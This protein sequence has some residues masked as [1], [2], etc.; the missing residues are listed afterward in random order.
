MEE[1]RRQVQQMI[2]DLKDKTV[3][4]NMNDLEYGEYTALAKVIDLIDELEGC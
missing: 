3:N 2:E 1:L 4:R